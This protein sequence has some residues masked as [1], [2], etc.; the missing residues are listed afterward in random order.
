M[1]QARRKIAIGMLLL[2]TTGAA[3]VFAAD[4]NLPAPPTAAAQAD[5]RKTIKQL[6]QSEYA[7]K[8]QPGRQA[9]ARKLLHNATTSADDAA[10]RYVMLT[11]ARDLAIDCGDVNTAL[12]AV[13]QI[14]S[15]YDV[16]PA[17]GALV[18]FT[19]LR[20]LQLPPVP[21]SEVAIDALEAIDAALAN[22]EVDG[23]G[24][25]AVIAEAVAPRT[26]DPDITAAA[27]ERAADVR[28][29]DA[30]FRRTAPDRK[31]LHDIPDDPK[32]NLFVGKYLCFQLGKWDEG[33]DLLD[34]GSDLKL[35]NLAALEKSKPSDPK[36][37][38]KLADDWATLA[39]SSHGIPRGHQLSRAMALYRKAL[40]SLSGLEKI[41]V[42]KVLDA[43]I[44]S[45][46]PW[47]STLYVTTSGVKKGLDLGR[48]GRNA[49]R[50]LLI[51]FQVKANPPSEEAIL[52]TKRF[53]ESDGSLT[54]ILRSSGEI[55]LAGDGSFY[56][57]DMTSKTVVSDGKWHTIT[58]EKQG[59]MAR[60]FV[61]HVFEGELKTLAQFNSVSPWSLGWH[62]V[63]GHGALDAE[64]RHIWIEAWK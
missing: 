52:L 21:E 58:V 7:D 59:E 25:L 32:A 19:S 23:A 28:A 4:A 43:S 15:K 24:K 54:V 41:R 16:P 61:D 62:E 31:T 27:R 56:H 35:H 51:Q 26:A 6:L 14:T 12:A 3:G 46:R 34:K 37:I 64:F 2:M 8:S 36:S 42:T 60:L 10:A 29:I 9:L 63:W 20:K 38:L 50:Q 17:E 33:L 30:E 48:A 57:T 11:E 13:S 22:G 40:P 53:K 5:A 49:G 18:A 47:D 44:V 45:V 39:E 1:N 55:G